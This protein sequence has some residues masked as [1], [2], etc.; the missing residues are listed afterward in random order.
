MKYHMQN[1]EFQE[2]LDITDQMHELFWAGYQGELKINQIV[3]SSKP[4]SN[5]E[6]ITSLM[7]L[8]LTFALELSN[9]INSPE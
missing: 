5:L 4:K 6:M 1:Y 8:N 7:D 9:I 2:A 3:S